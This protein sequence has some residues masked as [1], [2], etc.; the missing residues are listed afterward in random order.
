MVNATKQNQKELGL[1]DE[2]FGQ[3]FGNLEAILG[4][5]KVCPTICL[6]FPVL[7]CFFSLGIL[8]RFGSCLEEEASEE[9]GQCIH[10]EFRC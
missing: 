6:H 10:Q 4:V 1:T 9:R 7:N 8:Y 2:Q 3:L 5:H